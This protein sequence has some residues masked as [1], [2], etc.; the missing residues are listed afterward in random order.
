VRVCY[1][2][3]VAPPVDVVWQS[4]TDIDSVLAAL[5]W[6]ALARNGDSV[7]GSLKCKLGAAQVTYRLTARAEVGEPGF[8]TA[9]ITVAGQ[10]ARGSGT[11]AAVL[12]IALR[13]DG[14]DTRIEVTGDIEATGRG[15]TADEQ[16]WQRVIKL[17]VN[18]LVPPVAEAPALPEPPPPRTPL[19][20][21]PPLP[22]AD[23]SLVTV[24]PW[25]LI[26]ALVALVALI[27]RRRRSA[28]Q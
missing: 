6:A 17:L 4:L 5:P 2:V 24:P 21:A 27:T 28:R 19:A 18:A 26:A 3:A 13:A 9:M 12:T 25:A 11:V 20:V 23:R 14:A 10:E 1:E 7:T 8:R 22:D 16:S 15:E